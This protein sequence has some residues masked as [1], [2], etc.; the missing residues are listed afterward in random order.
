MNASPVCSVINRVWIESMRLGYLTFKKAL[1]NTEATQKKYLKQLL[2]HNFNTRYGRKYGFRTIRSIK[3]FQEKVPLTKYI[4]YKQDID[5]IAQGQDHVLTCDKVPIFEPSSG[6]TSASKLIPYTKTLKQEFHRGIAPWM[7]SLYRTHPKLITGKAYWSISPVMNSKK[8]HG[9]I[10]VGFENDSD[11]LGFLGKY[12]FSKITAVPTTVALE[13]D[14]QTFR[15]N[16]LAHLLLCENLSLMSVWNPTFLT[17]LLDHFLKN[18]TQVL[19]AMKDM[20]GTRHSSRIGEIENLLSSNTQKDVFQTL[21]PDLA[22]ISC[23]IDG[24]SQWYANM[25]GDYFPKVKIQGKGLI[26]TEAF[27]SFPFRESQDPVLAVNSHFFEFID[28]RTG[29]VHLAHELEVGNSYSVVVSTGGGLYRY[30]LED[31]VEVTGFLETAPVFRFVC[32][33]NHISDLAGEKLNE[34]HVKDCLLKLFSGM[35]INPEFYLL[36]PL[37]NHSICSYCLFLECDR[38]NDVMQY[39]IITQLETMLRENYHYDYCR[40]LGQLQPIRLFIIKA[41]G[42]DV[43]FKQKIKNGIK[44]GDVKAQCLSKDPGWDNTF[45]GHIYG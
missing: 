12:F 2:K 43:Y 38:L 8:Y 10:K 28:E 16:T 32:K 37:V 18:S 42:K 31:S 35:N 24:A 25:L 15:S 3:E 29:K 20:G 30:Q 40:R 5:A 22:V 21:W 27:V 33:S 44:A 34:I 41:N 23:W 45:E 11:Y 17:L 19:D 6:S 4:D 13:N 7:F 1:N 9:N 39:A 36:A 26:A 14:L